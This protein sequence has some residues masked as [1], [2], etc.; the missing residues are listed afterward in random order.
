ERW[1][2][3]TG[4][5]EFELEVYQVNNVGVQL[6]SWSRWYG[7]LDHAQAAITK[8]YAEARS[9]VEPSDPPGGQIRGNKSTDTNLAGDKPA[10]RA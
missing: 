1:E 9:K 2:M 6:G 10:K 7:E 8:L 5:T 4:G 3:S